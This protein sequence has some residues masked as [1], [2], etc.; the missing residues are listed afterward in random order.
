MTSWLVNEL[1]K[2]IVTL[3]ISG[4]IIEVIYSRLIHVCTWKISAF[5]ITFSTVSDTLIFVSQGNL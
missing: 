1:H 5:L 2:R 4:R 3:K